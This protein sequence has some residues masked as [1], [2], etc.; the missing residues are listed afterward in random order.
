MKSSWITLS[1]AAFAAVAIA[2]FYFAPQF[3]LPELVVLVCGATIFAIGAVLWLDDCFDLFDSRLPD[4]EKERCEACGAAIAGLYTYDWVNGL[5][6]C[7]D[8][9]P[10]WQ[11][12][13][14]DPESFYYDHGGETVYYTAATAAPIIDAYLAGGGKLSDTMAT[15][16][17]AKGEE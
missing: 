14:N 12:F 9:A 11:D 13:K 6:M 4:D 8:C 1:G 15:L 17:R 16:L 5:V 7:P 3:W 2:G 10:T